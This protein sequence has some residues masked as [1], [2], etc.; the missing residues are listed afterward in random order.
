MPLYT[1]I[2]TF[3]GAVH[4]AQGSH[5]NFTGFVS[6]WASSIGGGALSTMTPVQRKELTNRA[7]EGKFEAVS[8][9][10][11]V[12]RKSIEIGGSDCVVVAVQTDR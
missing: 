5:S 2:V 3:K 6:T 4:I 11:H 8:G 7:Y 10:A 9:A 12:W 1:Y